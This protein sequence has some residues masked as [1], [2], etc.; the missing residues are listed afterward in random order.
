VAGLLRERE[1]QDPHPRWDHAWIAARLVN[2]VGLY[3]PCVSFEQDYA[4]AVAEWEA[5]NR[6]KVKS[7]WL[8]TEGA[9]EIAQKLLLDSATKALA[10]KH[11]GQA[12]HD[13][14]KAHHGG[15]SSHARGMRLFKLAEQR[16]KQKLLDNYHAEVAEVQMESGLDQDWNLIDVGDEGEFDMDGSDSSAGMSSLLVADVDDA[17]KEKSKT[18]MSK[19]GALQK[20]RK[21]LSSR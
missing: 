11:G 14:V 15:F 9:A 13:I 17:F 20:L 6:P 18:L 2:K 19:G 4:T 3:S 10:A 5:D 16:E 21:W 1:I 8:A 12:A 7:G